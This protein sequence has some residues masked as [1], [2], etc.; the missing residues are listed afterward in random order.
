VRADHLGCGQ[1]H[2]RVCRPE[3]GARHGKN[4]PIRGLE[5]RAATP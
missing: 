4:T 3:P 2:G 1:S 5:P